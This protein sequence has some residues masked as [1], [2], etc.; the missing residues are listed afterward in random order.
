MPERIVID[1]IDGIFRV[2]I[3]GGVEMFAENI[4]IGRKWSSDGKSR[5]LGAGAPGASVLLFSKGKP[6][7]EEDDNYFVVLGKMIEEEGGRGTVWAEVGSPS[8]VFGKEK[9]TLVVEEVIG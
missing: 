6:R 9:P 1:E 5:H 4:R 8:V 2:V 3:Q 7:E